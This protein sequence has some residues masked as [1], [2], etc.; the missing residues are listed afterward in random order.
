MQWTECNASDEMRMAAAA[1]VNATSHRTYRPS[2]TLQAC[3]SHG[4]PICSCVFGISRVSKWKILHFILMA[5]ATAPKSECRTNEANATREDRGERV[6]RQVE[7]PNAKMRRPNYV[8]RAHIIKYSNLTMD[9]QNGHAVRI[10]WH[11]TQL[12]SVCASPTI[13]PRWEW[14]KSQ[15]WCAPLSMTGK[16]SSCVCLFECY[17]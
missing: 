10:E 14:K 11:W 6:A 3:T 16:G 2:L 5:A 15:R 9:A 17:F 4:A 12:H 7:K 13:A 8:R 1:A